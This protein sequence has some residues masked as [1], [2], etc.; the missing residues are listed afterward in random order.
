MA[1]RMR[2]T[3]RSAGKLAAERTEY[4][5]WDT[6]T[7]GLGVRVRPSGYRTWIHLDNRGGT[8]TRHTLGPVTLMTVDEA[9]SRCH[10][11]QSKEIPD[12]GSNADPSPVPRFREF[13]EGEWKTACL[14]RFKPSSRKGAVSVLRSQLLPEFGAM[15]LGRITRFDVT[16]WF[17]RHSATAPGGANTALKVFHQIMNR[18]IVHGHIA[19]N[20][21]SGIKRNPRPRL[22]RFLSQDEI[23]RLHSEL[24]RCV[25]ERPSRRMQADII[26]LLLL[27]GCRRSEIQH[28]QWHDVGSDSLE[29]GDSK[30]GPRR[31]FLN[32]TAQRIIER[33]PRTGSP[34]V[35]PSPSDPSRPTTG[36]IRLWGTVRKRCGFEDVRCHGLRHTFASQ[37]VLNGIPLP[38]VAKLLGHST[39]SMTLRYAHVADHEVAAAADRIGTNIAGMCG[40]PDA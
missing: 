37:A 3:D 11:I 34:Y 40:M 5:V 20:P 13:I 6:R 15:P 4:T 29:L 10:E 1:Q 14:N 2:L 27:T 21:A 31:V 22:T 19:A 18:A 36:W 9:R 39:V 8:S 33:Q 28:L 30:T 12:A 7:A 23:R 38:V 17:D 25:A 24:D 26:R 32:R 16:R 35:F